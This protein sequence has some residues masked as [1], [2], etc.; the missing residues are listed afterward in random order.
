MTKKVPR[1]LN[2]EVYP[3]TLLLGIHTPYNK[4][5]QI[6]VYYQEFLKLAES[7]EIID[8]IQYFVRIRSIDPGYFLTTGKRLE[9]Q[10]I[11][12]EQ[13]IEHV[14]LSEPL[15]PQQRRNLR[16]LFKCDVFD[17]TDLILEIFDKSATT[18]EGKLQV[19]IA[20]LEHQKTLLS[21]QGI[22]LAQQK[23]VIGI[24]GGYGETLKEKET[25]II[26][27]RI[28]T[29][30]KQLDAL[31]KTRE[32]QRKKRI[33]GDF[34]LISLVGYT[35]A[36]KSTILNLLTKSSVLAE[37]RLFATLDTT[38]RELYIDSKKV[39]LISDTV[40][41]LQL[42]PPQLIEAFKSTLS[43]LNYADLLLHV[44][45]ISD[46]DFALHIIVVQSILKDLNIDKE[47]LYVFNK[48]DRINVKDL[49]IS[50]IIDQYQPH[51]VIDALSKDGANQLILYLKNIT[52]NLSKKS[53]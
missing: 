27:D 1:L 24:R 46:P 31:F 49:K 53:K 52:K 26:D 20:K 8:P 19:A 7:C 34:P 12:T 13:N 33:L 4:T 36:G 17:R 44:V 2:T 41:F 22:G 30:K 9:I 35:N 14:V 11:C 10:K 29:L 23:G 5:E 37:D 21:G 51:V 25:R 15:T 42:L 39:G 16:K 3:K 38:T 43:E 28:R 45:D 50:R 48:A 32:T 18:G 47:L 6:N 40:G